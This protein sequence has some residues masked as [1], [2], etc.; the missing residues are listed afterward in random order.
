MTD[1]VIGTIPA[2]T[3]FKRMGFTPRPDAAL[4][5]FLEFETEDTLTRRVVIPDASQPLGYRI[6]D[7]VILGSPVLA[8]GTLDAPPEQTYR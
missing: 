4:A 8:M 5:V 2:N 3:I 1:L 7:T 6:E